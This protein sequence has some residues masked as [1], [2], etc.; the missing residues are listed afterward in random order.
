MT[1]T[2]IPIVAAEAV[3]SVQATRQRK[4]QAPKGRRVD[5]T[6]LAQVRELL[7]STSRQRDLLIE[8]LHKIQD[9]FG[10][11]SAAQLAALR[12]R[13]RPAAQPTRRR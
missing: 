3:E 6:A 13:L 2:V 11:L 7:G 4:R 9:H 12:L 10:H 8:H 5:V 1:Q